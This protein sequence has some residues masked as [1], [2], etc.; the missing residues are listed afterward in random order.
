MFTFIFLSFSGKGTETNPG[1][2]IG[3]RGQV[4][5][6]WEIGWGWCGWPQI[7]CGRPRIGAPKQQ[8]KIQ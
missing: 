6:P 8:W 2:C 7:G 5:R 3:Y 4:R 1:W